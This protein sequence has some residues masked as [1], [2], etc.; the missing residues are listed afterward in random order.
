MVSVFKEVKWYMVGHENATKALKATQEIILGV[1][2]HAIVCD[3]LSATR[4]GQ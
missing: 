3:K 1:S 2:F 4:K